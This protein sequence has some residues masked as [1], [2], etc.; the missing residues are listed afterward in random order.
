MPDLSQYQIPAGFTE[1]DSLSGL[2]LK[3]SAGINTTNSIDAL[4]AEV[5]LT[6][7]QVRT[8]NAT[9]ITVIAAPGAGKAVIPKV[10]EV[11]MPYGT[12]GYDS[13]GAGDDLELRYTNGSGNVIATVEAT[14]FLDATSNQVRFVFP[15]LTITPVANAAVVVTLGIGEIYG[16]AGDSGLVVRVHDYSIVTLAV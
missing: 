7:A 6:A 14:G 16:A 10:V 11:Y 2:Y 9:P 1:G 12:A 15:A 13:V 4:R 3:D 5:T 8:L